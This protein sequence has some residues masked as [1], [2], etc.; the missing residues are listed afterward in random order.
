[1]TTT[2]LEL[3]QKFHELYEQLAPQ[4]GYTTREDSR[5]FD[6]TSD[7]GR[8][9]VAVCE[10]VLAPKPKVMSRWVPDKD[11]RQARRIGKTLEEAGEL[12]AVLGRISIQGLDAIDPGTGKTNRQRLQE[13]TADVAAQLSKTASYLKLDRQFIE[14]RRDRK[15]N[16]M[17][18]WEAHFKPTCPHGQPDPAHC[19]FCQREQP[20]AS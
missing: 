19:F 20:R 8:L 3:A 15:M 14:A 17:D 1:M 10:Q 18:E 5:T 7:N 13:E 16:E 6:P 11:E 2:P 9:M 12:V 4:F